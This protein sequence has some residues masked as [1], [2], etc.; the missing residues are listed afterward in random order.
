KETRSY[1]PQYIA[2]CLIGM[3]P[4]KYGFTEIVFETPHQYDTFT[5]NEAIDLSFLASCAGVSLET[6][7][8]MNPELTQNS[9]PN[10]AYELKIP[11]RKSE[12]FAA[13][14][15][16]IPETAKRTYLVHTVRKGESLS[17]VAN[18]YGVTVNDLADANNIS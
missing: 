5:V 14:L 10:H 16:N 6:L 2:V 13:N 9:T 4:E 18:K 3:N 7:Q 11:K 15:Q 1:V 8:D 17:K 12:I